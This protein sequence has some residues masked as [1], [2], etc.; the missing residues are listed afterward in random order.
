ML[1]GPISLPRLIDL[2]GRALGARPL[3]WGTVGALALLTALLHLAAIAAVQKGGAQGLPPEMAEE[4]RRTLLW[5]QAL[6]N[7][8]LFAN[9]GELGGLFA[10][11]LAGTFAAQAYAWRT[12]HLELSRGVPRTGLLLA[13]FVVLLGALLLLPLAALAAGGTVT[14][15]YTWIHLRTLPLGGVGVGTLLDGIGRV[16]LTLAPYAA[17]AL[18]LAVLSRSTPVT[19]G[20]GLGYTL[21]VENLL[22]ELLSLVSPGAARLVRYLP[23]LAAKA[24]LQPI[25]GDAQVNVGMQT[26]PS[27][28]LLAPGPAALLLAL[29][30]L[31]FLGLALWAFRRQDVAV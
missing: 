30:T 5:P 8:L 24:L 17:L 14:G 19:L 20:V 7:A 28:S 13:K 25:A 26:A 12:V 3:L 16:T 23:T 10:V 22:A 15:L 29:Y 4:I 6:K 18:L 27:L 2:E 1:R 31:A 21:L 11:I 9:G